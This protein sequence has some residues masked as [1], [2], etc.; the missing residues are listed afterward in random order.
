MKYVAVNRDT[1][2]F[3]R[4][5]DDRQVVALCRHALGVTPRQ[6]RLITAGKFNTSYH[7]EFDDHPPV[8]LRIAPPSD[9]II[10]QH[11]R[12]LLRREAEVQQQLCAVS[13]KIPR[14]LFADFSRALID[15]DYVFQPCLPGVLWEDV[16]DQLSEVENDALWRQFGTIV[17]AIHTTP[18]RRFGQ[19]AP[20]QGCDRWSDAI[21]SWVA[22][23]VADLARYQ[24]PRDDARYF[25]QLVE[26]HRD[27]L[28]EVV[29]P[30]LVHGDLWLKNILIER[31]DGTANI[32]AVL[33]A[34]RAFWGEPSAE[35]IFSFLDIPRSFWGQYGCLPTGRAA[36]IRNSIYEGRGAIQLC[37][38]AWR[39]HFDDGFARR[40]LRRAIATLEAEQ[41]DYDPSVGRGSVAGAPEELAG[42][43]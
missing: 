30:T 19:P 14:N 27:C 21:I 39:F 24:C 34:E 36:K 33:D 35:W 31:L 41:S 16:K 3:Q 9:A 13:G 5:L 26:A 6:W 22:G 10:F 8:V 20:G 29:R 2:T 1:A 32:S 37:L 15:R 38:E 25:L 18:G 28:D 11:E 12:S 42:L 7:I 23:M 17:K 4:P 43:T 40:N